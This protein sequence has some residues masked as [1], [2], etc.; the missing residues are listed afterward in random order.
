MKKKYLLIFFLTLIVSCSEKSVEPT[1]DNTFSIELQV[2]DTNGNALPNI[3]I[4]IWSILNYSDTLEIVSLPYDIKS[5]SIIRYD[6]LQKCFVDLSIYNLDGQKKENLVSG[7]FVAGRYILQLFMHEIIGTGVYKCKIITST[8][9]LKNNILFQDSIYVVL[10]QPDPVVSLVG[11]TDSNG[12]LKITDKSLFPFFYKLPSIPHTSETGPC[13]IGYFTFSD[14]VVIA[15][16]NES[17]SK[18]V[19]F[20]KEIKDGPNTFLLTWSQNIGKN[21]QIKATSDSKEYVHFKKLNSTVIN[22]KLYQNYPNPFN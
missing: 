5:V 10:W 14:S 2:R 17:F 21:I 11:I 22:W 19:L 12:K 3:N 16:S 18:T 20:K 8:D 6:L 1:E 9:S 13:P 7:Q 4:S 15:L